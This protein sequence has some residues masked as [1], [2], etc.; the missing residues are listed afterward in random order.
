MR[1][2]IEPDAKASK[3]TAKAATKAFVLKEG[4][5]RAMLEKED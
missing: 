5:A 3:E 2:V 1:K 4:T